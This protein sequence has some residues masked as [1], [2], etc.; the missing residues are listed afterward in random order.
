MSFVLDRQRR[1][2][3]DQVRRKRWQREDARRDDERRRDDALDNRRHLRDL[4]VRTFTLVSSCETAVAAIARTPAD[5][6]AYEAREL[7]DRRTA[8]IERLELHRRDLLGARAEFDIIAP[9]DTVDACDHLVDVINNVIW[10]CADNP[11]ED[12]S[13]CPDD[14]HSFG[15][16]VERFRVCVRRD[17]GVR[18]PE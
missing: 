18:E 17:L 10:H 16:A 2:H 9:R 1:A 4:F 14:V 11:R 15:P 7:E 13:R 8:A 12:Q 5:V 6:T 3:D